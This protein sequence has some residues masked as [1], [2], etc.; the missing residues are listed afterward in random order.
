M[1][2]IRFHG[3][4]DPDVLRV[5]EVPLPVPSA[6]EVRVR[7]A[8]SAFNPVDDGIR[9]G[10]LREVFPLTLPHTPG[11]DVAG[12]VDAVGEGV[13]DLQVG[14]PVVGFLSMVA[15]GSAAEHVL[16]PADV[17]VA[18]PTSIPLAD[19]AALPS[20]AL[21]AW[22]ALVDDAG[23]VAGQR[24]LVNGAGGAVGGYAVQLAK[25]LGGYVIASASPRS[26]VSVRAN[27]ADEVV[28]H[29]TTPLG[30]AVQEP[31]DVL[32]NLARIS[33]EE[34]ADLTALVRD[35]GVVVNTVPM[36]PAEGDDARGVRAVGVFV[37]SDTE[38]LAR[39]VEMV[40]RGELHVD[41]EER[42]SLSDLP[43]VHARAAA[44][45]AF[46]KVVVRP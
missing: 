33:A 46:G 26:E 23:L 22:Q 31:V 12:T 27:G 30:G 21:T 14:D 18:A 2:A 37:R 17:L 34:L 40:D 43:S 42:L 38:Q 6:G 10:Y 11:S 35:G 7:V 39:L 4:G 29:T 1:K 15:D 25:H 44:G 20:V 16:A 19:A 5:E 41:V 32:V 45:E 13:R 28:D 8:G 9:G 3:Y 36:V 24:V